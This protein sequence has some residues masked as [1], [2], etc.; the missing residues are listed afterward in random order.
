[1]SIDRQ[2]A[3]KRAHLIA[4][5]IGPVWTYRQALAYGIRV[6]WDDARARAEHRERFKSYASRTLTAKQITESRYYTRRCG[7]SWT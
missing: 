2:S 1:M 5:R 3:M 4:S 6:A 7:A